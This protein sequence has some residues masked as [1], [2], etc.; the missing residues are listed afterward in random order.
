MHSTVPSQFVIA[1]IQLSN[2][3]ALINA[4]KKNAICKVRK[5]ANERFVAMK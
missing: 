4:Y 1:M 5:Q 2:L 3:G